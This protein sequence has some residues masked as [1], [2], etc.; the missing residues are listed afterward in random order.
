M[1]DKSVLSYKPCRFLGWKSSWLVILIESVMSYYKFSIK[2][3]RCNSKDEENED[4]DCR[5]IWNVNLDLIY[6]MMQNIGL[7]YLLCWSN[8]YVI[9]INSSRTFEVFLIWTP[10]R[11]A[12]P[13]FTIRTFNWLQEPFED[14]LHN[15]VG[16]MEWW[17]CGFNIWSL[18]QETT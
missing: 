12:H 9:T 17:L 2:C 11:M 8:N 14:L 10:S 3:L 7:I 6:V 4:F 16:M 15:N 13:Y 1:L 18:Q 5:S